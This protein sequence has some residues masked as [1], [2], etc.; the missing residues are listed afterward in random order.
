[1]GVEGT[2]EDADEVSENSIDSKTQGEQDITVTA[3]DSKTSITVRVKGRD[4]ICDGNIYSSSDA[5]I[6]HIKTEHDTAISIHLKDEY[7]I[8]DTYHSVN[9]D[10]K[11]FCEEKG[12]EYDWD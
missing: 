12:Y 4:I 1:M 10:L 9:N 2:G 8:A 6:R 3:G 5:L 11:A 7:A